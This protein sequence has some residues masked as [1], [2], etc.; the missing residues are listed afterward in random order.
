[1]Q[2]IVWL[3][4]LLICAAAFRLEA[5][6]LD[7]EADTL[8]REGSR[9]EA[10][11][12]VVA[13]GAT[14]TLTADRLVY[15]TDTGE[16]LASGSCT[17][18]D[19]KVR[20]QARAISYN[21]Q[22]GNI[23]VQDGILMSIE[24]PMRISGES[25]SRIGQDHIRAADA[26]FTPCTGE[27]PDWSLFVGDLDI[28]LGGYGQG[29]DVRFVVRGTTVFRT[30]WLFFPAKFHRHSGVLFPEMGHGSDYGYRFGLPLYVVL[31]RF[32]DA[33]FT[34]TYLSER[35]LLAKLDL[36]YCASADTNGFMYLETLRDR[37]GGE[38]REGGL[39]REIPE[40]RWFVRSLQNGPR[41]KWDLNFVSTPDYF[42]DIGVFL[43]DN[44]LQEA[45]PL[46]DLNR[47]DDTRLED[48]VSRAQW[49][50]SLRQVS[51]SVSALHRRDLT[52][53][54]NGRTVQQ[55]PRVTVDLAET[56][57]PSTPL[58][59]TAEAQTVRAVTDDWIDAT[60][61]HAWVK[62]AMPVG[63]R[64]YFT[65]TPTVREFYR[66]T[67]FAQKA[68]LQGETKYEE[69]WQERSATLSTGLYGPMTEHGF[70]HQVMGAVA[71]RYLS[72]H[73]GDDDARDAEGRYPEIL[74]EDALKEEDRIVV[75]L[76]NYLRDP[77]ASSL[78]DLTVEAVYSLDQDSWKEAVL[79]AN[80]N[81]SGF[82]T[83][84][85]RNAFEHHPG[86]A[87]A[88]SRHTTRLR[89]S[90]PRG[91]ALSFGYEYN[92]PDSGM[93]TVSLDVVLGRGCEA[94]LSARYDNRRHRF[95]EHEQ[96][97]RY[98]SQCW[99]VSVAC[100]TDASEDDSPSRTVWSFNVRLLGIGD[101]PVSEPPDR[102]G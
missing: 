40:G 75:S 26:R 49:T 74:P 66:D 4:A 54:D 65:F 8:H 14:M 42:R 35:G 83:L 31:S 36:R 58:W 82:V 9:I 70:R 81:P 19:E 99:S 17:L 6:M 92:R 62:L 12:H 47:L 57:I 98:T 87:Y 1:M 50:G 25:I 21:T 71:W 28:P 90:H 102:R 34:P 30:P 85:H 60:R 79:E 94:G 93:L 13:T 67:R 48:L 23:V 16:I 77:S 63:I 29:R 20:V 7:V 41:L 45:R 5:Y 44:L 43:N 15:D 97:L 61:N 76:S 32:A 95:E 3:T 10:S 80:C 39:E 96:E 68:D 89:V 73:G 53:A 100:R 2:R 18:L 84:S 59:A 38:E 37:T 11:G 86:D 51:W 72:R 64:P 69:R 24:G 55:L 101:I 78:A 46:P 88:T 52:R 33:T 22:S 27:T 56:R 91:D